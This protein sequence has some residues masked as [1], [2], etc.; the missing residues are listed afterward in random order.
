MEMKKKRKQ[1]QMEARKSIVLPSSVWN[2]WLFIVTSC[3]NGRYKY[4]W[5]EQ[6]YDE[7]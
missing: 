3:V 5:T 7:T 2:L 1:V 4:S 6:A